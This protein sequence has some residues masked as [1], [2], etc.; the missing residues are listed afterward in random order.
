M[1]KNS[2]SSI[3]TDLC[4]EQRKSPTE[5]EFMLWEHLRNRNLGGYKFRRQHPIGGYILDFYCAEAKIGIEL[6][7]AVHQDLEQKKYDIQ[8]STA[9][10]E[11]GVEVIRFWNSEVT[12]NCDNVLNQILENIKKRA[13]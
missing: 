6:D 3:T 12:G 9:L 1:N 2:F 10:S 13:K 4:R 8:R 5:A 7:G 11:L